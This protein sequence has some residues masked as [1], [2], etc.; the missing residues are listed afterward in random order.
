MKL[1]NPGPVSLSPSVRNALLGED[2]CHHEVEYRELLADVRLQ[3]LNIYTGAIESYE[4]L[5]LT[6]SGSAAVES[7]LNS[8]A[9]LNSKTLII[10]NG[11]YGERMLQ[12]MT[13]MRRPV[14]AWQGQWG[15]AINLTELETLLENN[16]DITHLAMVH[17]ET[18]TGRLNDVASV[19]ALCER[20]DVELFLDAVS[21]FA[22]EVI[23]FEAWRPLAVAASANKCLHGVPGISFV[24]TKK[25]VLVEQESKATSLYLDLFEY[26]KAQI[27]DFSPFTPAIQVLYAL[28]VALEELQQQGG[29][30]VRNQHYQDLSDQLRDCL[31][32]IGAQLLLP[33]ESYCSML[34]SILLPTGFSYE[35]LH[36][37]FKSKGFVIYAGQKNL[38]NKIYRLALMGDLVR[39]DLEQLCQI[40]REEVYRHD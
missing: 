14:I 27:K 39:S 3:L 30:Q 8:L 22:G 40:I 32:E 12:M 23:D 15:Q 2:L 6:G 9:P 24:M 19:A 1:L 20:Y 11:V 21:S 31:E 5:I 7:M 25:I 10:C 33:R 37:L 38:S 29:W 18:T 28:R 35:K 26:A 13:R 16:G 36:D 34:T 17:H 4:A